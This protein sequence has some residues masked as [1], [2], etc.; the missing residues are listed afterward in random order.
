M[1]AA[2][3]IH[4]LVGWVARYMVGEWLVPGKKPPYYYGAGVET[5]LFL[6]SF[7]FLVVAGVLWGEPAIIAAS[8]LPLAAALTLRQ[9]LRRLRCSA[10]A[11]RESTTKSAYLLAEMAGAIAA[12]DESRLL[13]VVDVLGKEAKRRA[14]L[15]LGTLVAGEAAQVEAEV[16]GAWDD[17]WDEELSE[18][19]GG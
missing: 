18:D 19:A 10:E 1:A 5:A 14:A 12:G 9:G 8:L 15:Q 3:R 7:L 6:V 11:I 2:E 17:E 13:R 4:H 16:S